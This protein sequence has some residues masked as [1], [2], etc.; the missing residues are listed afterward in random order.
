MR[1]LTQCNLFD[2]HCIQLRSEVE[3]VNEQHNMDR[4]IN[5]ATGHYHRLN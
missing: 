1:E 2:I 4:D 5:I 3:V